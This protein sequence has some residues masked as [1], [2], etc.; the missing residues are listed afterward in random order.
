VSEA[1]LGAQGPWTVDD[2]DRLPDDG[3]RYEIID[4]SLLVSPAPTPRHQVI[5][6][7]VRRLL[8]ASAGAEF[9]VLEAVGVQLPGSVLIPDVVVAH[10]GP[11]WSDRRVLTPRDILL[12]VEVVSPSSSTTDRVTKPTLYA[13]AGVPAYWRVEPA[14]SAA[15]SVVTF[16]LAGSVYA[17]Q[18]TATA[19]LPATVDWPFRLQLAPGSWRPRP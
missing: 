10:S 9:E 1:P 16:R 6:D 19:D 14:G 17:E 13:A 2:L 5:A 3:K 4:G 7:R 8:R 18:V 11:V 12:V 15:P